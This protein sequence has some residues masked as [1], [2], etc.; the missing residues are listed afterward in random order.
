MFTGA[1]KVTKYFYK[2]FAVSLDFA[3]VYYR[4]CNQPLFRN[5]VHVIFSSGFE[6]IDS[7]YTVLYCVKYHAHIFRNNFNFISV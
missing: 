2:T 4:L 6:S 3:M 5:P 1:C 7:K